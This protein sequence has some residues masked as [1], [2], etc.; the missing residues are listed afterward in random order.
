MTYT[1]A[2]KEATYRYREKHK[3]EIQ[4]KQKEY[5]KKSYECHKQKKI[6]AVLL[7]REFLRLAKINI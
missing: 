7:K 6:G 3:Q 1:Q 2:Q 4:E 5:S